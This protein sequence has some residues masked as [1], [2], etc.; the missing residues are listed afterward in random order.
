MSSVYVSSNLIIFIKFWVF[1]NTILTIYIKK[2]WLA[3]TAKKFDWF[4]TVNLRDFIDLKQS[5]GQKG[6]HF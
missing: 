5:H 1:Y 2:Y 3:L 6:D 4:V